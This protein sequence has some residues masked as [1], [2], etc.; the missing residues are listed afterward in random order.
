MKP[1]WVS[2]DDESAIFSRVAVSSTMHVLS[3]RLRNDLY[4]VGWGVKL[5]S[6]TRQRQ[7]DECGDLKLTRFHTESQCSWWRT[8]EMR[9]RCR[10]A[11]VYSEASGSALDRLEV[12]QRS[13]V[14][15]QYSAL[16]ESSRLVMNAWTIAF[17]NL[18]LAQWFV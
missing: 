1:S 4:C 15:P 16:L 2:V 3:F 12:A 7:V 18:Y 13:S 8:S 5:Y 6:I 14:M 17:V 9:S 10:V 11:S